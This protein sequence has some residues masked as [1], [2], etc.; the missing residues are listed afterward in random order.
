MECLLNDKLKYVHATDLEP[1]ETAGGR[2][3]A[4]SP[5]LFRGLGQ[6]K[7][8]LASHVVLSVLPTSEQPYTTHHDR[9]SSPHPF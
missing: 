4:F 1:E 6:Q 2:R 3:R 9:A 5:N 7:M 8:D